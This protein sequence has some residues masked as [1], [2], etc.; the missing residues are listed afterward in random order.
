MAN[1]IKTSAEAYRE[2]RKKQ[3]AQAAKKSSKRS[4]TRNKSVKIA[5]TVVSLLIAI[6]LVSYSAGSLL[7]NVFGLPQRL[8]TVNTVD[9]Y[10]ISAAEF[11][12][13]Y[14]GLYNDIWQYSKNY[15][16]QYTSSYGEGM[17]AYL[18]GYDFNKSPS[19]QKYAGDDEF[20]EFGE[21]ATWADY[22]KAAASRRAY[23]TNYFYEEAL[24][25][26]YKLPEEDLKA[27]DTE[28]DEV[29]KTANENDFSLKRYLSFIVGEGVN[30]S[31]F[32]KLREK[33]KIA[34]NY[35]NELST[36]Y[37]D[38]VTDEEIQKLYKENKEDYDSLYFR[39]FTL[40]FTAE[41]STDADANTKQ[42]AKAIANK[43]LDEIKTYKDF[44]ALAYKYAPKSDK[45]DYERNDATAVKNVTYT[46]VAD[47]INKD[48]ADWLFDK[49]RSL[50]DK[51][52]ILDESGSRYFIACVEKAKTLNQDPTVNVRHILVQ[53]DNKDEQG[54]E[55]ELTQEM[56]TAAKTEIESIYNE[57]KDGEKTEDSFAELAK[58]RSDDPGSKDN[59]GLYERVYKG[60]M[61]TEFEDWCYDSSR[62][63]GD[64]GIVKTSYGFHLMYYVGS[65]DE[66]HWKYTARTT[67][68]SQ[69]YS[70]FVES[71]YKKAHDS[72]DPNT[73]FLNYFSARLLENINR[74]YSSSVPAQ[75]VPS[76]TPAVTTA[77]A[78]TEE[79]AT[80]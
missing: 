32:R 6:S 66:P 13:Y 72:E 59:G 51:T 47:N 1:D 45:K 63:S 68:G 34:L 53:F 64:T 41:E 29:R 50:N 9:G 79:N 52:V 23:I 54:N 73:R 38:S 21:D 4:A 46:T 44:N 16:E 11:N 22:F 40:S 19:A 71:L 61:V 10:K 37:N 43:M 25:K 76:I 24:K 14:S 30:E 12:Y 48:L 62:K 27:I 70:D 33:D 39:L 75:T 3:I 77:A 78:D 28:I 26:E 42:E 15:E 67:L 55:V 5:V 60:Q 65:N 69:K 18:T 2:R 20:D 57:W 74:N 80:E 49:D 7:L 31:L 35:Q 58:T 17:G 36:E 8:I 56:I